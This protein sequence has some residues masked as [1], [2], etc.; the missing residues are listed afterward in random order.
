[1]RTIAS[2]RENGLRLICL[3]AS[4]ADYREVAV[5]MGAPPENTFNFHP[6]VRPNSCEVIFHNFDQPFRESRLYMMQKQLM[7]KILHFNRS[8]LVVVNDKKQARLT[9][10]DLVSELT[11]EASPKKLKHINEKQL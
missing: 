5:W 6:H 2:E 8:S 9:A 10:L 7:L 4:L 1:M 11:A 3:S